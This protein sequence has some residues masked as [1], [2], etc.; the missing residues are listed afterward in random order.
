MRRDILPT[1]GKKTETE[2][3]RRFY[4]LLGELGGHPSHIPG[5]YDVE[6]DT[7]AGLLFL[8]SP[9]PET[10]WIFARFDD[11]DAARQFV[12]CNPYSGKWNFHPSKGS[13]LEMFAPFETAL[14]QL[15]AK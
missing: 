4:V 5:W 8:R 6:L 1:I 3:Y 9:R 11:P 2:L 10:G 14:R 15:M 7:P 12:G 13:A